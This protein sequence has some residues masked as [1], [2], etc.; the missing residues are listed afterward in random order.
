MNGLNNFTSTYTLGFGR[1]IQGPSVAGA[2]GVNLNL[3]ANLIYFR[4]PRNGTL[5]N[6]ALSAYVVGANDGA[7]LRGVIYI[8]TNAI[9]PIFSSTAL[10]VSIN[11]LTSNSFYA[12]DINANTIAVI[13]GQYIVLQIIVSDDNANELNFEV[14]AGLEF[15]N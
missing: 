12:G 15:R 14:Q 6:L 8:G 3:G 9:P 13:Q 11:T 10:D 7:T 4:A 2:G 5:T 1:I